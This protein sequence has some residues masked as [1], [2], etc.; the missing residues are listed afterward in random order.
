MIC[1]CMGGTADLIPGSLGAVCIEDEAQKLKK[2]K[3]DAAASGPIER[4]P[5]K[6]PGKLRCSATG[7]IY[8]TR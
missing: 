5:Q 2:G 3:N 4:F 7:N 1:T 8:G 6:V